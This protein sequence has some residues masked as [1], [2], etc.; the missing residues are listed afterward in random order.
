MLRRFRLAMMSLRLLTWA[1]E[2]AVSVC[3]GQFKACV[4]QPLL[5]ERGKLGHVVEYD[6]GPCTFQRID[7]V[8]G[9]VTTTHEPQHRHAR[10]SRR[11]HAGHAVLHHD[12]ALGRN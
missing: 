3:S 4:L 8:L 6:T 1:S 5:N 7:L 10:A 9:C 12:T 2:S 11:G